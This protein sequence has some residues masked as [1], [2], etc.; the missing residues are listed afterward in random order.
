MGG[1]AYTTEA[2]RIAHEGVATPAQIDAIMRDCWHFRMGPF[3]LMDLTGID[4]NYP[5]S[6]I[7]AG[8][9]MDDPRLKTSANHMAMFD[10]GL[11]G[12]KS[13]KGWYEY[14]DGRPKDRP[15]ADFAT[16]A[17]PAR[18]VALASESAGSMALLDAIAEDAAEADLDGMRDEMT[19][20]D[21][22]RPFCAEIGLEIGE[23]DGTCPILAAPVG[24]DAT[25]VAVD[26]VDHA[27]LLCIDLQGDPSRRVTVMA[28]PGA[29]RA[30]LAPV[31]AAIAASGR[32]V[33]WINDS[34]GFVGQRIAAMVANL[35]CYMAEIGLAS[36]EDIDTAMELGLN[37]PRGSIALGDQLGAETCHRA[38]HSMHEITG[39]D[40]YRPAQW[41][42]RRAL[43]GLSLYTPN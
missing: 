42:R 38:L 6:R 20:D 41:L 8:G 13:G 16:D 19:G 37:Y 10:A 40:R 22:L 25:Y 34:P 30:C 39:D 31:A 14:A 21:L 29:D 18:K 33:T 35:G 4:V 12:R 2:L 17:R 28:A 3:E 36:P 26:G 43:L 1:R 9:Y 23:D 24:M 11:L 7:I 5:V 27:R 15:S 32:A